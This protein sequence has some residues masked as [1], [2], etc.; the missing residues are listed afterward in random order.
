MYSQTIVKWEICSK[1]CRQSQGLTYL[2]VLRRVRSLKRME[3]F[4][5]IVKELHTAYLSLNMPVSVS[6]LFLRRMIILKQALHIVCQGC[7]VSSSSLDINSQNSQKNS[8]APFWLFLSTDTQTYISLIWNRSQLS[9]RLGSTTTVN[10]KLSQC[11][12]RGLGFYGRCSSLE[13]TN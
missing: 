11:F 6:S 10:R 7:A 3:L 12:L 9:S 2:V 4:N 1:L 13:V 5:S 8:Q